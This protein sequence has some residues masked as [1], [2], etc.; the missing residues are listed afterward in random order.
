MQHNIPPSYE[1]PCSDECLPSEFPVSL[2]TRVSCLIGLPPLL[3]SV[4]TR[5][6]GFLRQRTLFILPRN[7]PVR[8]NDIFSPHTQANFCNRG[9]GGGG[10]TCLLGS[11][12]V[13]N[14]APSDVETRNLASPLPFLCDTL[15]GC[16]R[17]CEI[18]PHDPDWVPFIEPCK[19][20]PTH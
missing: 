18:R 3:L 19:S 16:V 12:V 5:H 6:S 10:L 11:N 7:Q 14:I 4:R 20:E 9:H 15:D 8:R 2:A 1:D 17:Y 13:H